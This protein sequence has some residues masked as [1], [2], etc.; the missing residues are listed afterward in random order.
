VRHA[1]RVQ[2]TADI[3]DDEGQ[4]IVFTRTRHGAD[5]LVKQLDRMGIDGVVLHG[6]R[7]QPQRTRALRDFSNGRAAA[8]IAT[9]VAARGIHVDDVAVVVHFDPAADA[10]DDLHSSGRTARAG[11]GGKVISLL[12]PDQRRMFKRMQRDID[13]YIEWE[14]PGDPSEQDERVPHDNERPQRRAQARSEDKPA[15]RNRDDRNRNDSGDEPSLYVAN[16]PWRITDH[17]LR[18]LFAPYGR[19]HNATVIKDRTSGRSRGFGFVD[20]T[21]GT[22]SEAVRQLHGKEVDGRSITVRPAD[23]RPGRSS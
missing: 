17:E 5:R 6:G 9:D 18:E 10:K 12:S 21:P 2:H 3:I 16:L 1:D 15:R 11:K 13:A 14:N 7:S 20:M 23:Q 19:V 4:A 22:S 8:L